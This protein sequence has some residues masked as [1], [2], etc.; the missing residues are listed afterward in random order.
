MDLRLRSTLV[1][2][3]LDTTGSMQRLM[4]EL[5]RVSLQE[6]AQGHSHRRHKHRNGRRHNEKHV[7][8]YRSQE[9]VESSWLPE[10]SNPIPTFVHE[11]T[12]SLD[13]LS[14]DQPRSRSSNASTSSRFDSA[15]GSLPYQTDGS[16]PSQ[17]DDDSIHSM[18]PPPHN[19]ATF[20]YT[21]GEYFPMTTYALPE[22]AYKVPG[23]RFTET[24]SQTLTTSTA[25]S[26]YLFS[27]Q[28][29]PKK[30]KRAPQ[31]DTSLAAST[32]SV[33]SM[34]STSSSPKIHPIPE[35]EGKDLQSGSSSST[36]T[37][38]WPTTGGEL[39]KDPQATVAALKRVP[40]N[41]RKTPK[42]KIA[43]NS[44][45]ED[46]PKGSPPLPRRYQVTPQLSSGNADVA[47]EEARRTNA[48]KRSAS[49][50]QRL[51]RRH[52]SFKRDK[53]PRRRVPVKRSFSDRITY[54]A[55]KGRVYDDDDPISTPS[56]LRPVG[57]LLDIRSG[58]LH[59][60]EL[61][62]PPNGRYGIYIIEGLT[63]GVFIS[64]FAEESAEK[65]F[66]GLLSP[67]D[68]IVAVNGQPTRNKSLDHVHNVLATLDYV[69]LTV[70]PVSGRPDW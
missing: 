5:D 69:I 59:V 15:I 33:N 16:L 27:N 6:R 14:F 32:S 17:T 56:L 46:T 41:K 21:G 40:R 34:S 63:G 64:R 67:G 49:I 31:P 68:E 37:G 19:H 53:T 55:R 58:N 9:L 61:H 1:D 23:L 66:S 35:A 18:S 30:H 25:M 65:F 54:Q 45:I 4:E 47:S 51:R 43:T 3:V 48:P 10:V 26:S 60:V 22:A 12:L 7:H 20:D 50:L 36:V 38:E 24:N 70:I 2:S 57:R 42:K 52:G 28:G 39:N 8:M 44:E 13:N 62:K 29:K 11:E